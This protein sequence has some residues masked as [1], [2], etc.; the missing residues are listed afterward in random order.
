M[1]SWESVNCSGVE[2]LVEVRGRIQD[3]PQ[4]LMEVSSYWL[5]TTY[6][7][8]PMPCS[9]AYNL[10]VRSRNS[11]GVSE[12]S[13]AYAG[14]TGSQSALMYLDI[15]NFK[16]SK[17]KS[18]FWYFF[19]FNH[20]YFCKTHTSFSP[21]NFC[22]L[23]LAAPCPPQNVRYTNSGQSVVVSWDASVFATMYTVYNVSGT[24]RSSL[25]RTAGLS[26]QLGDFDPTTAELTASNEQGESVPTRDITGETTGQLHGG[27]NQKKNNFRILS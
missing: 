4:A 15:P 10:T 17:C 14:V 27:R 12:P 25:C 16:L 3:S 5:P 23:S 1:A 7:E 20:S 24:G 13:S 11:A 6:F 18:S 19:F 8:V 26:C 2:Y 9:T 22:V 21:V